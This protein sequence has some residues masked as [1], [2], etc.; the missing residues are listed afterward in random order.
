MPEFS[1]PLVSCV[2]P[3]ADR[4]VFVP[5]SIRYFQSQDYSNTELVIVDDGNESVADLVPAD[6]RIRYLR[7]SGRR[8]LGAKRN[9]CVEACRGDLIMHWDDDDWMAPYRI[10]YQVEELL[11]EDAE[12]CGLERML[13]YH[14]DRDEV[15]LYQYPNH[16][17]PWLA[18][19]SLL[20]TRDFWRRSPFPNIQVA[21]DTRFV[22]DRPLQRRVALSDCQFYVAMIHGHNTSPKVL[23]SP[24]WTR[25]DADLKSFMGEDVSF[26]QALKQQNGAARPTPELSETGRPEA[27]N[28]PVKTYSVIMVVHNALDMTRLSTLE[29][30]RRI[31]GQDA[32]LVIVDNASNDGTE[33]W[34]KLLSQR[35]DIDLI[36]SEINLGH[37]PAL[38][39]ARSK[40]R[41]PYLVALDSDAFP[42]SD[43]WLPRLR[44]RLNDQV[45]V[46]GIHH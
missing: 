2:M 37:G 33:Q 8:S 11:R 18:G 22:W 9:E 45:K 17:C 21:S 25:Y 19:G 44:A 36:R 10:T 41:S 35:G 28:D 4:R 27:V 14:L 38:E 29:T 42:L 3:T 46:A 43:D 13:F 1:H 12:V 31:S 20:Y 24:Y 15:W 26:S 40:T 16:Q 34:L 30:L 5:Q 32:W 39:L 7:L 23:T 6:P